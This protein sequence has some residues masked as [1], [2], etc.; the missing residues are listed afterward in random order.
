MLSPRAPLGRALADGGWRLTEPASGALT[1]AAAFGLQRESMQIDLRVSTFTEGDPSLVRMGP[2]GFSAT[3][4]VGSGPIDQRTLTFLAQ[5]GRFLLGRLLPH[6]APSGDPQ[7]LAA[8]AQA[9]LAQLE[10]S[11][12]SRAGVAA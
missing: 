7:A 11:P 8:L 10:S 6:Y 4:R 12:G 1:G 9:L 2:L 5:L 3:P